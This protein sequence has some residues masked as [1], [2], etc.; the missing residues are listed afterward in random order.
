MILQ[1]YLTPT[2]D[3]NSLYSMCLAMV[4]SH[5]LHV[6]FEFDAV[7]FIILILALQV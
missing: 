7:T 6:A 3:K 5:A 1:I 2:V 4:L